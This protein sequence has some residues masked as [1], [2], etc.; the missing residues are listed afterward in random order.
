MGTAGV[1]SFADAVEGGE[2]ALSVAL[3]WH[4]QANHYPPVS[5]AF[6]PVAEEAIEKANEG[7]WDFIQTYPNGL[8]RTVTHTVA[9][10][11]LTAFMEPGEEE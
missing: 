11:H 1:V 8:T 3:T 9:S 7:E 5:A 4:L 6:V 10:L 2:V